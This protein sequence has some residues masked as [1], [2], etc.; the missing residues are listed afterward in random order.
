MK[1]WTVRVRDHG[2]V[3]EDDGLT[4]AWFGHT[5]RYG[6]GEVRSFGAAECEA[7]ARLLA[8]APKMLAA[9]KLALDTPMR[10]IEPDVVKA[11]QNAVALAEKEPETCPSSPSPARRALAKKKSSARPAKKAAAKTAPRR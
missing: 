3:V 9:I 11:F 1:D 10:G 6:D 5:S 2:S 4:V 7:H 8:A